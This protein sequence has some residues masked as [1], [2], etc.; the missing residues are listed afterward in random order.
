MN[1]REDLIKLAMTWED[2]QFSGKKAKITE[3]EAISIISDPNFPINDFA[4][5]PDNYFGGENIKNA[6]YKLRLEKYK[7]IDF[8][9][10]P[11]YGENMIVEWKDEK[12]PENFEAHLKIKNYIS[13]KYLSIDPDW[14]TKGIKLPVTFKEGKMIP[15]GIDCSFYLSQIEIEAKDGYWIL[16][17]EVLPTSRIESFTILDNRSAEIN[18]TCEDAGILSFDLVNL[19]ED[20]QKIVNAAKN[21]GIIL[22]EEVKF[23]FEEKDVYLLMGKWQICGDIV[24][25]TNQA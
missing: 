18:F 16:K 7:N 25:I 4:H 13:K 23:V 6:L 10:L 2:W 21:G 3:E 9:N 15:F 8:D 1:T 14:V 22:D 5:Y 19:L 17:G 11:S 12:D 20:T 24:S